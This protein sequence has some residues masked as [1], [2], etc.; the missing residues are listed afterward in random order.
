MYSKILPILEKFISK[1][2]LYKYGFNYSPM[3]RRTTAR[4]YYITEDL[5][6]I[7]VKIPLTY[8][9]MNYVG[10]IFGGSMS[11]ATDPVYMIQLMDILGKNYVVWDKEVTIN[12][13]APARETAYVD[14]L[15]TDKEIEDIKKEVSENDKMYLVKKLNITNKDG[16]VVFAEL[17]KTVY[18]ADKA[19]YKEKLKAKKK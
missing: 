9:N 15:F 17:T 19:Y 7:K 4:I 6:N 2:I 10:S 13:K 12:F 1:K 3:Y 18:I 5:M 8:K 11:S 14:F 16:S